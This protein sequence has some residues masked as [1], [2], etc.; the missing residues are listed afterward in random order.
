MR[1]R[2]NWKGVTVESKFRNELL[3]AVSRVR[4]E[5]LQDYLA[6]RNY[7]DRH[8]KRRNDFSLFC[9]KLVA[10]KGN[11]D[12]NRTLQSIVLRRIASPDG[13]SMVTE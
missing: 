12:I 5:K 7:V 9:F 11:C 8:Q 13:K 4:L 6:Q 10:T 1:I 3:S 2:N